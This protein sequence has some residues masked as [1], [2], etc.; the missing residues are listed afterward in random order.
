MSFIIA[1]V[2]LLIFLITIIGFWALPPDIMDS[3]KGLKISVKNLWGVVKICQSAYFGKPALVL[4]PAEKS[5]EM[6]IDFFDDERVSLSIPLRDKEQR[7][8]KANYLKIFSKHNLTNFEASNQVTAYLNRKDKN[9]GELIGHIY[10]E[11][12]DAGSNDTIKFTAKTLITDLNLLVSYENKNYKLSENHEFVSTS[13]KHK[14]KSVSKVQAARVLNAANW[15][16]YPSTIIFSYKF[17]DLTAM[18]WAALIFLAFFTGYKIISQKKLISDC[19]GN[20]LL[21]GFFAATLFTQN[22]EFIQY[23]PTLSG[24]I[25]SVMSCALAMNIIQPKGQ[26]NIQLKENN[27]R[28]YKLNT[29]LGIVSGIVLVIAG[30]WSRRN[31]HFDEWVAFFAF[32]RIEFILGMLVAAIPVLTIFLMIENEP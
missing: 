29:S 1:I 2:F 30:E 9:L 25:L 17:F 5:I 15:L 12:F 7:Q 16:L 13:A 10:K 19:W 22:T 8:E 26:S 21:I 31:L 20:L 27:P 3:E 24:I 18:C 32:L 6:R 28:Q 14:G 4:V 23:T 11:V